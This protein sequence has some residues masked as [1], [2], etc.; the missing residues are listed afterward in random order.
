LKIGN[1]KF[2]LSRSLIANPN[3]DEREFARRVDSFCEV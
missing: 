2:R 3:P 1:S